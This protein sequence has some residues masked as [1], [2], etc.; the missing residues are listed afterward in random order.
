[1]SQNQ[2]LSLKESL[3][4][5]RNLQDKRD[6]TLAEIVQAID[7]KGFGIVLLILSLPS[8][9]PLPATVISSPIGFLLVLIAWQ[10]FQGRHTPWLPEK[11]KKITLPHDFFQKMITMAIGFLDKVEHLIKPR[12][13]WVAQPRSRRILALLVMLMG[14]LMC[15]PIPGT[16]TFPAMVIFLVGVCLTEEDG[17]VGILALMAGVLAI[18]IYA[19]AIAFMVYFFQE[20]GWSAIDVFIDKIKEFVKGLLG[21]Q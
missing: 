17:A 6:H 2:H 19:A 16:N 20:Y 5:F 18:V 1:M 4:R 8:A 3:A 14:L 10:M 21:L 13:R 7:E 12:M 9:L 15:I 11:A